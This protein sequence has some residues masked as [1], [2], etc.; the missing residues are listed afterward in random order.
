MNALGVDFVAGGLFF[1]LVGVLCG[2]VGY[3]FG[4][5]TL[6]RFGV[7]CCGVGGRIVGRVAVV[8]GRIMGMLRVAGRLGLGVLI[9]RVGSGGCRLPV[10]TFG[11]EYIC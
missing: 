5:L 6:A 10:M 1:L 4:G 7:C 3:R 8:G 2:E 11:Y 9:L